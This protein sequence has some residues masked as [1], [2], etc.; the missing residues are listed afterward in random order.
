[1]LQAAAC[2]LRFRWYRTKTQSESGNLCLPIR[3]R[4][5]HFVRLL[6]FFA[7]FLEDFLHH[8]LSGMLDPPGQGMVGV[9]FLL[10]EL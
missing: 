10:R 8:R 6:G 2:P 1:M 3:V 4:A 7:S 9:Q 5:S